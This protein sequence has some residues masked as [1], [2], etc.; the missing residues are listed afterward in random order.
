MAKRRKGAHLIRVVRPRRIITI[1]HMS[2]PRPQNAL[3][4]FRGYYC[5]QMAED[6]YDW[7]MVDVFLCPGC[8]NWTVQVAEWSRS[9]GEVLANEA[10]EDHRSECPALDMLA[11][12]RL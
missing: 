11:G 2:D 3:D 12:L 8:N 10:A 4:M 9:I 1:E 7:R 5:G 6:E